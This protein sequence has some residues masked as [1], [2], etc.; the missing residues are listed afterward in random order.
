MAD[1]K[2]LVEQL[3]Q[4]FNCGLNESYSSREDDNPDEVDGHFISYEI[5]PNFEVPQEVGEPAYLNVYE[6]GKIQFFHDATPYP[7]KENSPAERRDM[8]MAL[9]PYPVPA[10]LVTREDY[11]VFWI[12][13]L[14]ANS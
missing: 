3:E 2:S 8:M 9:N 6:S 12:G 5:A 10:D 7:V 11:C 14:E 4:K 13:L 1:L